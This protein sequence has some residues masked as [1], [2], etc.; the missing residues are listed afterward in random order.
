MIINSKRTGETIEY[1]G[2]RLPIVYASS[3]NAKYA[4]YARNRALHGKWY[5]FA[6]TDVL[7]V[8]EYRRGAIRVCDELNALA[9]LSITK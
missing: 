3:E 7:A 8:C 6:G 1:K 4:V 5:V 9:E 2:D